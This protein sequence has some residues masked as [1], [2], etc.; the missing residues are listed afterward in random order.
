M[1]GSIHLPIQDKYK[2][3]NEIARGSFGKVVRGTNKENQRDVAIKLIKKEKIRDWEVIQGNKIPQEVGILYKLKNTQGIIQLKDYYQTRTY[4]IMVMEYSESSMDLFY[5]LEREGHLPEQKAWLIMT[6]VIEA[7][8]NCQR[9][10]ITYRDLK[11]ENIIVNTETLETKLI[12]FGAAYHTNSKGN[13]PFYGTPM[14]IPP[15]EIDRNQ[16]EQE[17]TATW[18][19]GVILYDMLM[20]TLP[21][22]N[23]RE[24]RTLQP[25]ISPRLSHEVTD[26]L[27]HC[28]KKK[29]RERTTLKK[30]KEHQWIKSRGKGKTDIEDQ[31][32]N[33]EEERKRRHT[34]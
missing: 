8:E 6:Q 2:I 29:P 22:E 14:Y 1:F 28:L 26:L 10:G 23:T 24:I 3:G 31:K 27:N 30:M 20:G 9:K 19:I 11:E 34:H 32:G 12:D 18:A 15:E 33:Y 25:A 13:Q 17:K 7:I 21:F 5:Y 4:A 16:D